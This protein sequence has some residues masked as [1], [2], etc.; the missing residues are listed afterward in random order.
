MTDET[1]HETLRRKDLRERLNRL[2]RQ[3]LARKR[4]PHRP[5]DELRKVIGKQKQIQE[6][7]RPREPILYQR[8]LP[9][10]Q[11]PRPGFLQNRGPKVSLE[12]A[13][14]GVEAD[15][16]RGR[17]FIITN[18]ADE[19]DRMESVS[20]TFKAQISSRGSNLRQRISRVWN[21]DDLAPED[22]IF[23]DIETTGLGNSPLFLIGVMIWDADGF[24]IRQYLAR[25]YAEE[26]A[27]I[28]LFLDICA[29][30]DLLVT[31]NGKSYDFPYI[32]TRAI[33]NGIPFTLDPVHFDMLHECRRI[34]KNDL[35]DCKLQTLE[36]HICGRPRYGDIPGAQIPDA[37]HAY[38]RTDN[39]WQIV[40]VLKHNM[41]DL[42]T[43]AD[44]MTRF[45]EPST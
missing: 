32:R 3:P 12:E 17:G 20:G 9:R 5:V 10:G 29:G 14:D 43:M 45:P 38:V 18:R 26:A 23:M 27:V 6:K 40:E 28:S 4:P 25:N 15:N 41:L 44:L 37:Y 34:W 7:P 31:F 16:P 22:F 39:A 36:T 1:K 13:V 24:E 21:G 8:D 33:A 30:K 19:Q 11:T 35:P 42:V 2:N